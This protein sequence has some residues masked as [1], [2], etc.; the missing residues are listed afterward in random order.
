MFVRL[1]GK[2]PKRATLGLQNVGLR[3]TL[4]EQSRGNSTLRRPPDLSRL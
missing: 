2:E 1:V 3:A 4:T